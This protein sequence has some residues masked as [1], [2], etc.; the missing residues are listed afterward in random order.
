M[1]KYLLTTDFDGTLVNTFRPPSF[2]YDVNTATS[3]AIAKQFGP[4]GLRLYNELGGM[5]NREPGELI[6]NLLRESDLRGIT[7]PSFGSTKVATEYF[8]DLKLR[9]LLPQI[10]REWPGLYP[11]VREFFQIISEGVLPVE[12][13]VVSS[14]HDAFI[15]RV[16]EVNGLVLP[17]Y[18]VTSDVIR[19]RDYPRRPRY[20]PNPYQLA[21]AHQQWLGDHDFVKDEYGSYADRGFGKP[22]MIYIG[23]DPS[24]DG[25]LAH[26]SRISFGFV[27]FT[28]PN[29]HPDRNKGQFYIDNF[30]RFAD[31]LL[32]R[33]DVFDR[34]GSFSE[35]IFNRPDHEFFPNHHDPEFTYKRFLE[36]NGY[37][38]ESKERQ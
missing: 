4:R 37:Y 26:R 18:L 28:N 25:G 34:G 33:R 23:D 2:G 19:E 22:N 36:R 1:G 9:L 35:I 16:F 27:P 32:A 13:A 31:C 6:G 20:K 8:V 14:G 30:K 29:F 15:R 38:K 21:V 11:G 5:Q 3:L 24:R 17:N 10:S 12:I 7:M